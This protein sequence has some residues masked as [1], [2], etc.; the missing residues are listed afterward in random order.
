MSAKHPDVIV[1]MSDFETEIHDRLLRERLMAMLSGFF[2]ALAALL[3]MVGLYGVISYFVA[4][5]R[6]EIG[7]RIALGARRW[8]VV[9]LVMRDAAWMLLLGAAAG[10]ALS[11]VGGRGVGSMLFGLKPYDPVTLIAALLLLALIAAVASWLP[12]RRA[13]RLDPMVALRCE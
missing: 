1:Q 12:A 11:L 3:V 9:G 5:R 7:V 10:T 2:G 4:L 13:S 8:Q 6:A